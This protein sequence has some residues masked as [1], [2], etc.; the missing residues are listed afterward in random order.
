MRATVVT[1][2]LFAGA[3]AAKSPEP[4]RPASSAEPSSPPA[5]GAAPSGGANDK[6]VGTKLVE[7]ATNSKKVFTIGENDGSGHGLGKA[8][9]TVD[10]R[11]LWPPEGPGCPE[12]V[13]CCT[14][15]AA[16][17]ES[18]ALACQ[19]AVGRDPDCPTALHTSVA[20]AGE[21]NVAPPAACP[22]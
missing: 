8:S 18:L 1:V 9:L 3:C 19:L 10:G 4:A 16:L 14:E 22:R 13:R 7:D 2:L 20:I 11:N 6:P 12:L 5:A 15:L 17:D 21:S